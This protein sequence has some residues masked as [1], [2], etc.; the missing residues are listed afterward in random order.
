MA[1]VLAKVNWK[2]WN[3]GLWTMNWHRFPFFLRSVCSGCYGSLARCRALREEQDQRAV[4]YWALR[5]QLAQNPY[6]QHRVQVWLELYC[7]LGWC[8]HGSVLIH[9]VFIG[10][11][12]HQEWPGTRGSHEHAISDARWVVHL[13]PCGFLPLIMIGSKGMLERVRDFL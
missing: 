13:L 10:C 1:V 8:G 9:P 4:K 7:G 6:W 5:P 2:H 3:L 12:V 11:S